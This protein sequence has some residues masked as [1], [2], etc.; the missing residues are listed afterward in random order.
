[1]RLIMMIQSKLIVETRD[2]P[3]EEGVKKVQGK[4]AE[5]HTTSLIDKFIFW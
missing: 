5:Y 2:D 1:M 3:G 4:V